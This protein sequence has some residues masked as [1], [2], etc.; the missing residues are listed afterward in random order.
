M[1]FKDPKGVSPHTLREILVYIATKGGLD[2]LNVPDWATGGTMFEQVWEALEA[3]GSSHLAEAQEGT[4]GVLEEADK[5]FSQFCAGKEV[6]D[7][8]DVELYD[9]EDEDD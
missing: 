3:L 4:D 1:K 7:P 6:P 2:R 8:N 5:W 9:E